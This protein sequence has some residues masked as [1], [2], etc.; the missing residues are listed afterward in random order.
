[1]VWA[2]ASAAAVKEKIDKNEERIMKIAI[3]SVRKWMRCEIVQ[4][5]GC[6]TYFMFSI[7][8]AEE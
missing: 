1:M 6:S 2:A 5:G 8:G 4:T 3:T 7:V